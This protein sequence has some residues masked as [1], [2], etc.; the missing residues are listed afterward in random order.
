MDLNNLDSFRKQIAQAQSSIHQ[1][2]AIKRVTDTKIADL[3]DLVR[4]NA[5]FLPAEERG[6]ELLA[7]E[8]LKVPETIA[9]AVKIALFVAR[10]RKLSLT[11]IQIKEIAQERGF[12]FS[13]YS[14]PMAS[15]HSVLK[16]MKEADPPEV[17]FDEENS[18]YSFK[19]FVPLEMTDQSFYDQLNERA[20]NQITNEEKEMAD[21][22]ARKVIEQTMKEY[23][24][25][26]KKQR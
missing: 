18:T 12:D 22:I 9:E 10:S 14:N 17:E 2:Y 1:L 3:R 15:V 16:R 25:K 4:A 6:A 19:P 24:E 23:S 7:L 21:K 13:P 5:N 8:M 20:W 11:P 26:P